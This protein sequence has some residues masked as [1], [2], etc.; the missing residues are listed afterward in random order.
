MNPLSRDIFQRIYQDMLEIIDELE[1]QQ[2]ETHEW[3]DW[4]YVRPTHL[5][6][7]EYVVDDDL[8]KEERK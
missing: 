4:D 1:K 7:G 2:H 8:K 3:I 5:H 6:D